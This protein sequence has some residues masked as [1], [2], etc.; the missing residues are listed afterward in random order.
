MRRERQVQVASV[1]RGGVSTHGRSIT[2]VQEDDRI[3]FSKHSDPSLLF[4]ALMDGL[5]VVLVPSEYVDDG[6]E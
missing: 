4:H 2:I 5:T 3:S 6:G 1:E